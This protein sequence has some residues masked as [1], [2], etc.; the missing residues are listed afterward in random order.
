MSMAT[1]RPT[2]S[3]RSALRGFGLAT[4]AAGLG[5]PAVASTKPDDADAE[6]IRLCADL[7]RLL[8]TWWDFHDGGAHPIEDDDERAI[9]LLPLVQQEDEIAPL[10][11]ATP[12]RTVEVRAKA[13]SWVLFSP[14]T[15]VDAGLWDDKFRASILRDLV[16]TPVMGAL[17][18]RQ[19]P[20]TEEGEV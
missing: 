11:W 9:A 2:T 10:I 15:L 6:L 3:R 19:K 8:Q 4:L 5:M 14:E 7:D 17:S 13:R 16:G 20:A 1:P 12:A 18:I